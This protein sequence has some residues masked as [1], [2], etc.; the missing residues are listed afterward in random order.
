MGKKKPPKKSPA[1]KKKKKTGSPIRSNLAKSVDPASPPGNLPPA[2]VDD[3]SHCDSAT[4]DPPADGSSPSPSL[5]S[6]QKALAPVKVVNTT[7]PEPKTLTDTASVKVVET[8]VPEPSNEDNIATVKKGPPLLMGKKKPP[9][10][11]PAK[12]KKKKTGSPIRSNL[13]KSVDP[14]S[15]SGNLPPATVDDESHCDSATLDPHADGSSPSPCLVSEQ[16]ALAP[17]KVVNTTVPEPKTLTDT[18]S[19]KVVETTVPEPSKED[20]VAT[21][22]GFGSTDTLTAFSVLIR[23][24]SRRRTTPHP[25]Q[26][27]PPHLMGKKKPPKKPPPKK[28]KKKSQSL[29]SSKMRTADPASSSSDSPPPSFDVDSQI[30]YVAHVSPDG[31][32]PSE[33]MN[34]VSNE[35]TPVNVAI[36]TVP[37]PINSPTVAH[38]KVVEATV[39]EP[40]KS[41][42]VATMKVVTTTVPEPIPSIT[43]EEKRKPSRRHKEN[44]PQPQWQVRENGKPIQDSIAS[45]PP[46]KIQDKGDSSGLSP[47]EKTPPGNERVKPSEGTE[48]DRSSDLEDDSSDTYSAE[49]DGYHDDHLS[50]REG[51]PIISIIS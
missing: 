7:V 28:K 48:E 20:N 42:N 18:A 14:A 44:A 23:R 17:V 27:G 43:E 36:A 33:N 50:Q 31:S 15:P 39:P 2:T 26:Q 46:T 34:S 30:D 38:V 8:T 25:S 47:A 13:A 29:V 45:S 22:K 49:S 4:L 3:E 41:K 35:I 10:K 51:H 32:S 1:K 37:E 24:H 12:K 16:K 19:V 6:E 21:V 5:V 40:N 11:S 9:N